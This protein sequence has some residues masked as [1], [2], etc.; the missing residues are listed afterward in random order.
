MKSKNLT[1][2]SAACL[3]MATAACQKTALTE[4]S[5]GVPGQGITFELMTSPQSKVTTDAAF[6][7][8]FD[9]GD[10][11][12]LYVVQHAEGD[13]IGLL[14]SGNLYDN[15]KLVLR[16][17][18]WVLDGSEQIYFPENGDLLD[19]YAYWPYS[20]VADPTA[21]AY[22]ASESSYDLLAAVNADVAR[23]S[24]PIRLVFDHL[25]ALVEVNVEGR[26]ES[27]IMKNVITDAVF[28]LDGKPSMTL[29][30]TPVAEVEIPAAAESKSYRIYLPAQA[31]AEGELFNIKVG[32][33]DSKYNNASSRSLQAGRVL[34]YNIDTQLGDIDAMPNCYMLKPGET[35]EIP[36]TKAYE[37]WKQESY[38]GPETL[39]GEPQAEFLWM[40]E[41]GLVTSME[42]VSDPDDKTKSRIKVTT[43]SGKEGNA[44]VGVRIDGE[45]RWAWH[46]WV[47]EYDPDADGK[48][49]DYHFAISDRE[50]SY[51]FMDRNLGAVTDDPREAGSIGLYYQGS[52]NIPFPGPQTMETSPAMKTLYG[53][54]GSNPQISFTKITTG[55]DQEAAVRYS[56]NNPT[57]FIMSNASPATSWMSTASSGTTI[58]EHFWSKQLERKR[59][60]DPCP[61]GWTLP[62]RDGTGNAGQSIDPYDCV[63]YISDSG[64]WTNKTGYLKYMNLDNYDGTATYGYFPLGGRMHFQTGKYDGT[65]QKC[66]LYLGESQS[67]TNVMVFEISATAVQGRT[68]YG[69][70]SGLPVRCVRE[71][72]E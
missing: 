52:R 27:V 43:A 11:V 35:V 70:A 5:P 50:R 65:G 1:I 46:I 32:E 7:T 9:E 36:V 28:N 18:T 71:F 4:V 56:L 48:T 37:V 38:L 59:L 24:E 58:A 63:I 68:G 21:I 17:G 47:T 23:T 54:D 39:T 8:V 33:L 55:E 53:L 22:N 25:L 67:F 62:S 19:F 66:M 60:F 13:D 6:K 34:Q 41:E 31:L 45:I 64:N 51:I 40:D 57:T 44:L 20:E 10:E 2:L 61:E 12:G 30:A 26:G 72:T 16:S 14:S 15:L 3:L 42:L 29:G 69:R 49:Y